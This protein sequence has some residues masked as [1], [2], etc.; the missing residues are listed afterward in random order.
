MGA[1]A[2][3]DHM[4]GVYFRLQGL[5]SLVTQGGGEGQLHQILYT[6]TAIADKVRV[7]GSC[8]VKPLHAVL[9]TDRAD[10]TL[11]L[12]HRMIPVHGTQRQIRILRLQLL[13]D[14][15]CFGVGIGGA[16]ACQ[17]SIALFTMIF[18]PFHNGFLAKVRMVIDYMHSIAQ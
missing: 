10:G 2:A 11:P 15:F 6:V 16:D 9:N 4:A 5:G 8:A 14:P 17:N 12:E 1:L 7:G 18:S 3:E 13:I